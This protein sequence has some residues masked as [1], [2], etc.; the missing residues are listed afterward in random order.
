V[1]IVPFLDRSDLVHFTSHTVLHNLTEGMI[2]VSIIFSYFSGTFAAPSL[3]RRPFPSRY[4][5]ID[6]S[7]LEAYSREPSVVGS[8]DFGMVSMARL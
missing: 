7:G 5:C 6:L 2:L 1:K 8:V 4:F 3:L